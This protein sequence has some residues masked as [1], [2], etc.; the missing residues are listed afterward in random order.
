MRRRSVAEPRPLAG[1][2]QGFEADAGVRLFVDQRSAA[3]HIDRLEI[4]SDDVAVAEIFAGQSED[5]RMTHRRLALL[6]GHLQGP[7]QVG[8]EALGVHGNAPGLEQR[9]QRRGPFGGKARGRVARILARVGLGIRVDKGQQP[10]AGEHE[11]VDGQK[12]FIRKVLRVHHDKRIEIVRQ[13]FGVRFDGSQVEQFVPL[14]VYRPAGCALAGLHVEPAGHLQPGN[15]A[16]ARQIGLVQRRNHP[17]QIV[18]EGCFLVRRQE[19][20]HFQPIDRI[21]ADHTQIEHVAGLVQRYRLQP[22]ARGIVLG[23][24]EW[25]RID[26]L[27]LDHAVGMR[28]KLLHQFP[29]TL[30]IAADLRQIL[31][32][33]IAEV[34]PQPDR[35]V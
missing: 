25:F 26:A 28:G 4:G 3:G 6:Y 18:F 33:R 31:A 34:Q 35:L 1:A 11:L 7:A 5:G 19:R 8:D 27:E 14:V 23:F 13:R 30:G 2:H 9:L 12:H 16:H 21:G 24:R 22:V 29:D 15:Q 17:G 20:Q 32:G 10:A